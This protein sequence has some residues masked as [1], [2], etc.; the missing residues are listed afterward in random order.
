MSAARRPDSRGA[1]AKNARVTSLRRTGNVNVRDPQEAGR[2]A[3]DG[4]AGRGSELWP[5]AFVTSSVKIRV[6]FSAAWIAPETRLRRRVE[7]A[8]VQVQAQLRVDQIAVLGEQPLDAVRRAAFLVRREREDRLATGRVPSLTNE[9]RSPSRI[10]RRPSRPPCRG[11]R[12]SRPSRASVN[13]STVQSS[14]FAST[15]SRCASSRTGLP[16]PVPRRRT[17]RFPFF[18]VGPSTWMSA[19]GTPASCS[20]FAMASAAGVVAPCSSVVSI[21]MSCL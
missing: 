19:A 11:R 14:R 6:A 15:T 1:P 9:S 7:V 12:R 13:G 4:V 2:Q 8:A 18:G 3:I 21:S 20:R 10:A 16:P 17:T 5:P